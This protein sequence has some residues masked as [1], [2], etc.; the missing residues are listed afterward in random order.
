[1]TTVGYEQDPIE[2]ILSQ[3][4]LENSQTT[5]GMPKPPHVYFQVEYM[6]KHVFKMNPE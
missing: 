6:A 5:T 1:M 3:M 2:M 4:R